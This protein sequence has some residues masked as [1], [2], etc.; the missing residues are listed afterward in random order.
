MITMT[1]HE[2]IDEVASF[3]N[4]KNRSVASQESSYC[5]YNGP[6]GKKCAFARMCINPGNLLE[7]INA[8]VILEEQG[9]GILKPEYRGYHPQFYRDVQSLHDNSIN[10]TDDGLSENGKNKVIVLKTKYPIGTALES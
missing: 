1:T 8:R 5:L 6:D 2:I 3:Y 7:N 10:W 9:Q 4:N